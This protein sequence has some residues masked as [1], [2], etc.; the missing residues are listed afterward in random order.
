MLRRTTALG[1]PPIIGQ[2]AAEGNEKPASRMPRWIPRWNAIPDLLARVPPVVRLLLGIAVAALGMLILFRPLTSLVLLGVYVGI[3]VIAG[4]LM[5][6]VSRRSSPGWWARVFAV[7]WIAGGLAILIWLGRS[8]DLLPPVLAVLLLIGGLTSFGYAITQGSVTERI[9]AVAWGAAQLVFGVLS[10]SWPD[11]TLLVVAVVFGVRTI[12]LGVVFAAGAGRELAQRDRPART[13]S[14]RAARAGKRWRAAGRLAVSLVLVVVAAGGWTLNGWLADGAPVIDA[15]YDPPEELP[16]PHGTLIRDDEYLGRLP[17]GAT[18]RRILYSTQ[19]AAGRPV[20]GSAVVISPTRLT[21]QSKPVILWNH[22]TT[23]IARACAPSLQDGF[24]TKWGIPAADKAI[25]R[26]WV[27]VAPD[28][29]GQGTPGVFPYL[30]GEGEARSGLDAVLAAQQLEDVSLLSRVAIW[31]HSQGGHAA[32]WAGSIAAEYAPALN[33]VGVAALS[34][35]TDPL[36][37]AEEFTRMQASPELTVLTSWVLV[38]YSD[39]YPDV[40]VADYVPPGARR[41]VREM[42]QRCPTE[43][44]V[45]VSVLTAMGVSE[46]QPLFR[47]DLTDGPLGRRLAENAAPVESDIPI[48]LAWGADDEVI[49]TSLYRRF[50]ESACEA[51]DDL[52]W[53]VYRGV[54]HAGIM[55]PGSRLLSGL[56]L[57]TQARFDDGAPIGNCG[58]LGDPDA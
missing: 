33:V 35:V 39:T 46:D 9:L 10:L 13:P 5:Q 57:W 51:G 23:G 30:I 38:P 16:R 28:Y 8:L 37:L 26:G 1:P 42:S 24:A 14:P 41:L 32:L 31:G 50:A 19:D 25:E 43:P 11:V 53:T 6:L 7:S 2:M 4:G 49:P 12:V 20:A 52:R 17:E 58:S 3:S 15:F 56:L 44:S 36:A 40:E 21:W 48:L 27:I 47:L 55:R 22:G 45:I 29:A 54:D 18:A 34:P